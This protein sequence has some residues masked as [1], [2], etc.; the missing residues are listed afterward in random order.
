MARQLVSRTRHPIRRLRNLV[1][2]SPCCSKSSTLFAPPLNT[3]RLL[4]RCSPSSFP[5]S[6]RVPT[7]D[8]TSRAGTSDRRGTHRPARARDYATIHL[9]R[10]PCLSERQGRCPVRHQGWNRSPCSASLSSTD[11][12]PHWASSLTQ[13]SCVTS[14]S[15]L[16]PLRPPTRDPSSTISGIGAAFRSSNRY[17]FRRT[18]RSGACPTMRGTHRDHTRPSAATL[19]PGGGLTRYPRAAGKW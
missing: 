2:M 10:Q 13:P 12:A 8:R 1:G 11:A 14:T 4:T 9:I 5:A 3:G 16:D 18:L 6:R 17:R 15:P 7:S 19:G